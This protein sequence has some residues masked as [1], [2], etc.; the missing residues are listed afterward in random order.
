MTFS[1]IAIQQV[2]DVMNTSAPSILD[3]GKVRAAGRYNAKHARRIGWSHHWSGVCR[4]LGITVGYL[5]AEDFSQYVAQFQTAKSL[6]PDGMLG[7]NTWRRM[8]AD[9]MLVLQTIAMPDWLPRKAP[10]KSSIKGISVEAANLDAPWMAIALDEQETHWRSHDGN[11]VAEGDTRVDEGYFEACPYMGGDAWELAEQHK[12]KLDNNHWCA[13]FVNYCLHTAGYSHTGSAGAFSF[14]QTKRW[15]F[16][17]LSEP[18]RGCVI[19]MEHKTKGYHHVS[20]LDDVGNLPTDPKG[21]IDASKYKSFTLLGGNQGIGTVI[22]KKYVNWTFY[23]AKDQQGNKSPYLFP[24]KGE[25]EA[26]CNVELPT[27]GPHYCG[28]QWQ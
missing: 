9:A 15:R 2:Y 22:S 27:A 23:A 18:T 6:K 21:D 28:E 10:Q 11:E 4:V 24:I 20:F 1:S 14:K 16:K 13:A 8:R 12:R 25:D 26:N 7:P 3:T 5:S 19:V 17:A